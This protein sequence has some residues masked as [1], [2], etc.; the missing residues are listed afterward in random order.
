MFVVKLQEENRDG[1]AEV[2]KDLSQRTF[3]AEV[4]E[5]SNQRDNGEIPQTGSTEDFKPENSDEAVSDTEAN[6]SLNMNPDLS[7]NFEDIN[8]SETLEHVDKHKDQANNASN[9][10]GRT[11]MSL[12][13]DECLD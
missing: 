7:L 9:E 12:I 1:L 8:D 2:T 3:S 11:E 6:I 10:I 5:D 13:E 4:T